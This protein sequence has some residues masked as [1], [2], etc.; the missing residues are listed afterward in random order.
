MSVFNKILDTRILN[1]LGSFLVS[2]DLQ[3]G[4]N[5]EGGCDAALF[6][7][8]TVVNHFITHKTDVLLVSLDA[9]AAFDRINVF[10]LLTILFKRDRKSVV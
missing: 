8:N 5:K 7:L 6:T 9:T 1:R 2:N 4:C 3:F 10:R